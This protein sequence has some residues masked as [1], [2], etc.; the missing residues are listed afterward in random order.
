MCKAMLLE[1][2]SMHGHFHLSI[3]YLEIQSTKMRVSEEARASSRLYVV[4]PL[5]RPF[6]IIIIPAR[7]NYFASIK[8]LHMRPKMNLQRICKKLGKI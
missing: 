2:K 6:K 3:V 8:Y 5:I 1:Q 7:I 4:T